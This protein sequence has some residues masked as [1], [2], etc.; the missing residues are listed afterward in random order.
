MLLCCA[1]AMRTQNSQRGSTL[2]GAA[3]AVGIGF[4]I[5]HFIHRESVA[6]WDEAALVVAGVVVVV[7]VDVVPDVPEDL[8]Q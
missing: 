2:T 7:V 1:V 8:L 6:Y 3:I 4:L 5:T